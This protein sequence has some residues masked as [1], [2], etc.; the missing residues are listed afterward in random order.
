MA[1]EAR[2]V[3]SMI[4]RVPNREK[5][6]KW[7]GSAHYTAL[8][9][10]T[11]IREPRKTNTPACLPRQPRTA[12]S[13]AQPANAIVHPPQPATRPAFKPPTTGTWPIQTLPYHVLRPTHPSPHTARI[14]P[15]QIP[16][17]PL[18]KVPTAPPPPRKPRPRS[19]HHSRRCPHHHQRQRQ[20]HHH[21]RR[22]WVSG[23]R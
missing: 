21:R 15:K 23:S 3:R 17:E 14:S 8:Q 22:R 12:P 20:R 6:S 10:P 7:L 16:K 1:S 5:C 2:H 19:H 11:Y 13:P 4:D 9:L 18:T